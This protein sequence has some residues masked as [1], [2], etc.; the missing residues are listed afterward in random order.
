MTQ[1]IINSQPALG[2][3]KTS[4]TPKPNPIRLVANSFFSILHMYYLLCIVYVII[5]NF[6]K[7]TH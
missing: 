7:I 5:N 6:V 2:S 4:K 3:N 1:P